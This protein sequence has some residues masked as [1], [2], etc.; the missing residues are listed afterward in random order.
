MWATSINGKRVPL[1]AE[2]DAEKGNLFL[3]ANK[4]VGV[5]IAL[6]GLTPEARV[7]ARRVGVNLYVSHFATCPQ[8]GEWRKKGVRDDEPE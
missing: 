4:G 6:G 1:D 2:P 3:A 7:S 5:A 8:A